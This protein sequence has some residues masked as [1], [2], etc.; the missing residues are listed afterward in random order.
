MSNE[1]ESLIDFPCQFQLKV[2]GEARDDFAI[3]VCAALNQVVPGEYIPTVRPSRNGNYHSVTVSF[4]CVSK[5]ILDQV[6]KTVYQ[7]SGV[8][9]L[10]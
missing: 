2:L 5:P 7:V 4:F 8:R 1:N 6:H 3:D 9:M 10:L